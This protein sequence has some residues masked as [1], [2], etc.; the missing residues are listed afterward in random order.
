MKKVNSLFNEKKRY[1]IRK[2]HI[3]AASIII[4]SVVFMNTGSLSYASE[5]DNKASEIVGNEIHTNKERIS[6][7]DTA[8]QENEDNKADDTIENQN[9]NPENQKSNL[10]KE[11]SLATELPI[12]APLLEKDNSKNDTQV[13]EVNKA[14]K[15]LNNQI[16]SEESPK[17]VI[18]ENKDNQA[19]Q[20]NDKNNNHIKDSKTEEVSNYHET[21][22]INKEDNLK[23][24]GTGDNNKVVISQ[25]ENRQKVRRKRN[26]L[27]PSNDNNITS[28]AYNRN[29]NQMN[30]DVSS[31]GTMTYQWYPV[32]GGLSSQERFW[33]T[34]GYGDNEN[35]ARK[36]A[37]MLWLISN[38]DFT[39]EQRQSFKIQDLNSPLFGDDVYKWLEE[40]KKGNIIPKQGT[41]NLGRR[42]EMII[43]ANNIILSDNKGF[44]RGIINFGDTR[45]FTP[46][47]S[48]DVNNITITS[49]D[50]DFGFTLKPPFE[51]IGVDNTWAV[52]ENEKEEIKSAIR[53]ANSNINFVNIN[54]SYNGTVFAQALN[55][56]GEIVDSAD[57]NANTVIIDKI[58]IEKKEKLDTLISLVENTKLL[59][60][61][62]YTPASIN[63]L[64]RELNYTS[65]VIRDSYDP[66][67]NTIPDIISATNRLDYAIKSLVRRAN[68]TE[69][70]N[71]ISNAKTQGPFDNNIEEDRAI[72]S[73]LEVGE[74]TVKN[75]N[76]PQ[77]VVDT[78][79]TN[80]NNALRERLQ[81]KNL[82]QD[83]EALVNEAEEKN[84][85]ASNM[86][87]TAL[88]DGIFSNNEND[89]LTQ[90]VNSAN[91]KKAEAQ[92]KINLLPDSKKAPFQNRIDSLPTISIPAVNDAD[93]N[94]I[95]DD[96]DQA[97][98]QAESKV[99]EAEAADQAAKAKL[100]EYQQDGLITT[101]EKADL[102]NLATTAQT[103]K[104]EAQGLVDALPDVLKGDLPT[105]LNNLTGIQVPEVNDADGNGIADDKDRAQAE[106]KVTEAEAADQT[107]KTKLVEY[108]EDGLITEPEK[109]D[110]ENL[111]ATAQSKKTEAQVLVDALP[112]GLKG[113]LATR[114]NNLTSIQVPAVN[115]ADDNGI[116]DDVDQAKAQAESKVTEAEAADQVAKAKLSEYQQDGLITT[117]EKKD[118]ENLAATAQ[119]K[120]AE[121]QR[122]VDAL[123]DVLKGDLATRLNNLTGI[124]VP[125]VNDA[126]GNGI[127]DD[128]DQAKAQAGSKVSEAEAADQAA[129]AKLTEYQQD[130]LITAPEKVDLDN[131][132]A[133][134]QTAKT[135]AQGL[136]DAL[137]DVL[138]G[139]LA[140]RL[141]N[142][143]GIQVPA[144]NDA[145]DNGIADD[146][147]QAKA[148]AESKVS[149]AEAADQ[150]AK[151][152]LGEYQQDGLITTPEKTD[153]ENLAATAQNKKAE[154]QVLVDALPDVLKN[155]L[156][157]RLNNLTGI[158]VPVVNDA[159]GNGIADDVDQAK[160]QAES[161]VSEAEA[162]DQAAKTKLTEYQQDGLIT[163]SEKADLDNLVATAQSK[164]AEAQGLVDAL[165]GGLKNDL[166]TRLN[167]LTG[168]Q[169]PAVNDADGN[170][171]ADD[172]DQAKAQ[173]ESK[174][175]EAEAA[176]QAAKTKL[177]EY[178]QDGLI[179]EPEKADLDSL[180]AT[181]QSK[182]AEA[183]GL[184]DA[185]PDGMKNDLV[186]RLNNLTGIQVPVVNDA[187]GNGVADDVDQAKAQA[188]S[189][190]SEAEAAD[191]AAKTKLTEYQQDGLITASE[192]ADLDNLATTAQTAKTEAQGLVDALPDVLKGD[193]ATRLNNLTGIQVPAVNDADGNG[194]A[195]VVDQAKAQAESKVTEA[196]ASYQAAKAK[197][198][199]YQQDGLITIT[200]R[201]EI[202]E[203]IVLAEKV[204]R[205]AQKLVDA[206]AESDK[207]DLSKR[208][209]N[210]AYI[211]LPLINDA[212]GNGIADDID[213]EIL[214]AENSVIKAEVA[215]KT[216]KD[217]LTEYQ[218]DGLVS[219]NEKRELINLLTKAQRAKAEAQVLVDALS[220]E[221]RGDLP[222]RLNKL[223]GIE[224]PK[225]ND[226][227]NDGKKDDVDELKALVETKVQ[228]AEAAHQNA[229]A[230][231]TEYQQDGL[232]KQWEK[233][234]ILNLSHEV[235]SKKARAFALV[236]GLPKEQQGEFL[237]RLNKLTDLPIPE[238]NDKNNNGIADDVDQA[239]AQ[240]ES[241]VTEAEA[242]DQAAKTKLTEY[243]QDGLIT[244]PEKA[245]LDNLATTAQTAKTEAQGLVDA[246]PDVLKGDL[247]TRLNN[248]TGIQVPEV[249]DADGNGIADDKDR[250]QAENKV[251][252]AEAADQTAKTKLV[253]YQEDGLIT[254]P[255]KVDLENLA[256]TAQSK[257][258]EAQ[259]LVD[260]LPDGL[261]GDLATRLNNLTGIQVPALNDADGNGIAD[262]VDQAKAQAESKVSEAEAADQ[263]AKEKLVEYQQDGLITE[264]EK[265]D[266]DNLV[267]T[268]Q[269]AKT[270]AQV[271]VD[272]L[273]DGL[274][275]DM[276]TRLNNLTGIQVPAVNDADGNGIAD[277]V[278]QSKAQAESKVTE[279]EAADQAAKTKL[280]EYQEDGLITASE[281]AELD[282]LATTAQSKKAE[283][284]GLVDA[285]PDVLKGDLA[286]RLNNLT[287]IQVP[288]VNDADGNGIADDIDQAKAQ[289]ESKVTEAEAADQ[290]A[291]IK[292]SE[293]QQ[294]GLITT[295]EKK[296]LEN[297][298][299]TAQSKKAEAQRLVDALPDVLK[300]DL[301]TRLN[302]LTGIQVPA[303]NDADGN[304]I[305]DDKDQAK[306]Q[307]ESKVTEAEV[308][309]QA[310]KTKL[311][312]YQQDGLIT[313][314]EK[315]DL[316][317]LAATA[318]SKKAEAQKL[319]DALPNDV[320]EALQNRLNK[321]EGI[322]VPSVSV[323]S[324][325]GQSNSHNMQG[326]DDINKNKDTLQKSPALSSNLQK[327]LNSKF[328]TSND[329]SNDMKVTHMS[330]ANNESINT[331][332]LSIN[333][334]NTKRGKSNNVKV[335]SPSKVD[336]TKKIDAKTLPNTGEEA[337]KDTTLF[338]V[339]LAS[340]GS[341]MVW[342]SRKK[343]NTKETK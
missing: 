183:Q 111:A 253:E 30:I 109:V 63:F 161:K 117:P 169:V 220:S 52:S 50:I 287:G 97:K 60:E 190:V 234:D 280:T 172:V 108:Q 64:Q 131:L 119:S 328:D 249:N 341:L 241:K 138:K 317:N 194:I 114:L 198:S 177:V 91:N 219:S 170:G 15:Q 2:Y 62:L 164:K 221:F 222:S 299:A 13:K 137:P 235:F 166:V 242:A 121:A 336:G 39:K 181:A 80:I 65:I 330:T 19:E 178:Q 188:E 35:R 196:E 239:K 31:D 286:T 201:E 69:L 303:V 268:A 12:S 11:A 58:F 90:L 173:A 263:A 205:E 187:D 92:D 276:S 16:Y 245:D 145:D 61:T 139:D 115:D 199:E 88:T 49:S 342:R 233:N 136:V 130:G 70:Q 26:V 200:E 93:N 283:A 68:V 3:G 313:A 333:S 319:V 113:D 126:D 327:P 210:L 231:L 110:L 289:A 27:N 259:V 318:Q 24:D 209:D 229:L 106:N 44:D 334:D 240:A 29:A 202:E 208:L 73:A 270:E 223:T 162:A 309:D 237:N 163:A 6:N 180:A 246:L 46:S 315:A 343:E 74:N 105:R 304:G 252:E 98:A 41:M 312:E 284:Q 160:A 25:N 4:G 195:D 22:L 189:K 165:P 288:A 292:L 94:G 135:E 59:D 40:A 100:A 257:K 42:N 156:V 120:K 118:L 85:N 43:S 186:T 83:V 324:H 207:G 311:S 307:A 150:A 124:Q 8:V 305:A 212:D 5:V 157:T 147:D 17:Q 175:S 142:L 339:L 101:P 226:A 34:N 81:A 323:N 191:Q 55:N 215:D 213:S 254:E 149:E 53:K 33:I 248:L 9:N 99:S 76:T 146:V 102:D 96:K 152:K 331:N 67:L 14:D 72:I 261:K 326:K 316:E 294:D 301:A 23:A 329:A 89:V 211:Q 308:A 290:V 338:G 285:L 112:D 250:A 141:N 28:G 332:K 32:I 216:V 155:D 56:S 122:L 7:M 71:A 153:L 244:E 86:L 125:A 132:V 184:V 274:K 340:I 296:D 306:A 107:A 266:L 82:L 204:K 171:I 103:A 214:K 273:P 167:N 310:A 278:D 144:V 129:K 134:A 140:T 227:D 228:E 302:N 298:A 203:L 262:D 325:N 104:T 282:N 297:L 21:E 267:A 192:K 337:T 174:V 116:A 79:T 75:E 251:T 47:D 48:D 291:K 148:Q 243:Q 159:D 95:A 260:A 295:P 258:T 300:D 255:E 10:K 320:K 57:L 154:A 38:F 128:L 269:T 18:Q 217:K 54:V 133:T 281:K 51:K 279:A 176:D 37:T 232:I 1:S 256:A 218:Q 247:P 123:P 182:K 77:D 265:V 84:R 335:L 225:V 143:T 66:E 158:Q 293:Y 151:T 193:L 45:N 78:V 314:S 275:G 224:I 322:V 236:D 272:A 197:L 238:I 87:V 206:L 230:K 127:A 36:K 264:P 168:I 20:H 321:L 277:D 185:L 271:L 179:T